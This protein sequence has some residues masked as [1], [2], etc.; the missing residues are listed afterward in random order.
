MADICFT[1]TCTYLIVIC[2][3]YVKHQLFCQWPKSSGFAKSFAIP[4]IRCVDRT[5]FETRRIE[6]ENVF[7]KT[8]LCELCNTREGHNAY[9][10]PVAKLWYLRYASFCRVNANSR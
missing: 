1:A 9:R 2:K 5:Y 3:V 10:S 6:A 7:P 4:R 8:A